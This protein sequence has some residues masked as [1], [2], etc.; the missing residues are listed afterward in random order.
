MVKSRKGVII[1]YHP[2][3]LEHSS[4]TM[5]EGGIVLNVRPLLSLVTKEENLKRIKKRLR[6]HPIPG[7]TFRRGNGK[8]QLSTNPFYP[9]T[10]E[11]INSAIAQS[12]FQFHKKCYLIL[13]VY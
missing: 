11:R 8:K 9:Q 5:W 3:I 6:S 12:S 4:T 1:L 10:R 13:I 7:C 2:S